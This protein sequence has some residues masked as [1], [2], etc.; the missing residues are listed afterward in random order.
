MHLT[1]VKSRF[2][3]DFDQNKN[4]SENIFIFNK[5]NVTLKQKKFH[6]DNPNPV[7]ITVFNTRYFVL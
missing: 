5:S 4:I 1:S 3:I 6:I 2:E 7:F